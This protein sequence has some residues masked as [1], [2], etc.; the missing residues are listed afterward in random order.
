MTE[1][2]TAPQKFLIGRMGRWV[3]ALVIAILL[4]CVGIWCLLNVSMLV[5]HD[6]VKSFVNIKQDVIP[7]PRIADLEKRVEA[8]EREQKNPALRIEEVIP[9]PEPQKRIEPPAVFTHMQSEIVS[10]AASVTALQDEIKHVMTSSN[11]NLQ[12][13]QNSLAAAL[14]LIQLRA[15]TDA[16]KTFTSELESLAA[17]APPDAPFRQILAHLQPYA[18]KGAPTLAALRAEWL[19]VEPAASAALA[20]SGAE[21]FW[22]RIIAELRS[23]VTVRSLHDIGA[24]NGLT[25]IENALAADDLVIA[26]TTLKNLPAAAQDS[27]KDWREKAEA[28]VAV[29][30]ALREFSTPHT[31]TKPEGTQ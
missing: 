11:E 9:T 21:N 2:I 13:A 10:L 1:P 17:V 28:R 7:D 16:G 8:L 5:P 23:I 22:Q 3:A 24:A 27:L 14:A 12:A 26:L 6:Q 31:S 4:S 30:T 20:R 15:A 25:D 29:D 18:E 19:H